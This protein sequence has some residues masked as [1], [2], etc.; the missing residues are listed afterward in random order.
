MGTALIQITLTSN[1]VEVIAGPL[2]LLDIRLAETGP[3]P[4]A[5][6]PAAALPVLAAERPAA[7]QPS[8]VGWLF[9]KGTTAWCRWYA[10]QPTA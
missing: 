10:N 4:S 7:A 5:L 9:S 6:P 3:T 2:R 8:W 1:T